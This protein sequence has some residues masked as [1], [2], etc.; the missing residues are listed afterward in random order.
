[1]N[2]L[3]LYKTRPTLDAFRK[4]LARLPVD[5]QVQVEPFQREL[6][7]A[8][9]DYS[10]TGN[11]PKDAKFPPQIANALFGPDYIDSLGKVPVVQKSDIDFLTTA[12]VVL[13]S[14]PTGQIISFKRQLEELPMELEVQVPRLAKMLENEQ[15]SKLPKNLSDFLFG[16]GYAK[17]LERYPPAF[18]PRF[19]TEARLVLD[20]W[21]QK[22]RTV[23]VPPVESKKL[24]ESWD[25]VRIKIGTHGYREV[26]KRIRAFIEAWRGLDLADRAE[27]RRIFTQR[28]PKRLP[29]LGGQVEETESWR[30]ILGAIIRA[31][32]E[33]TFSVSDWEE[34]IDRDPDSRILRMAGLDGR[35]DLF[36][37]D[38]AKYGRYRWEIMRG[39]RMPVPESARLQDEIVRYQQLLRLA[40]KQELT[41]AQE[42]EVESY[43][44]DSTIWAD[45]VKR[46]RHLILPCSVCGI[47]AKYVCA[48]CGDLY[49]C[50][51]EC[52]L[53]K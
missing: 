33:N 30:D 24:E 27:M 8:L 36:H 16:V 1:M 34:L 26:N 21:L 53:K 14:Y 44:K 11:W 4:N 7:D 35:V 51:N 10:D 50:S 13:A 18:F 29:Y 45:A 41:M 9:E 25:R 2:P 38:I 3:S 22:R 37:Q 52:F 5:L 47:A 39:L 15:L 42:F 20:A 49:F 48:S 40:R 31:E 23:S 12:E 19:F 17:A 46:Y 28:N 32:F 6:Y 43:I